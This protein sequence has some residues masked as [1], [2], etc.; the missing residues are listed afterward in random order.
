[1]NDIIEFYKNIIVQIATPYSTGTG[2]FLKPENLIVTN[3]HVVRSNREVIIYGNNFEKQLAK[4][5]FTDPKH[6]LAFLQV[7]EMLN[8]MPEVKLGREKNIEQGDKVIAIGHPFGM[9]YS[10]TQGIVSNTIRE[11]N[12]IL[13][14]YHDAALNPGNSGGPLIDSDGAIVGVNTFIIKSGNSVGFSLPVEYLIKTIKEFKEEGGKVGTRCF[15]CSNLVF[16]NGEKD[17]YC[18]HCGSKIEIPSEITEYEPIG[19][20]KTIEEMLTEKGHHVQLARRGPFNWEIEQGS[21]RISISYYEKTGLIIGDAYL[22]SLPQ[23][24]INPLYEFLLRQNYEMEGLT[25]SVRGRD[26]VLSLLIYDRYLNKET[27]IKLIEHLFERADF[28]DNIL[29]EKYG[30]TWKQ[31]VF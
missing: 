25:F 8:N 23:K 30:A 7:P 11:K 28:Y 29:V 12:D 22:C 9:K 21:A 17:K 13:Y 1:M 31:R 4:V 20:A 16:E 18:P 27:G 14:I 15:S 5:L 6:D 26:I 19:V 2:F 3:E 10:V 24:D